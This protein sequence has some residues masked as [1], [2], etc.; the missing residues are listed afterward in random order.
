M[1]TIKLTMPIINPQVTLKTVVFKSL[2]APK[3]SG[4]TSQA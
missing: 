1:P 2:F 3:I 4:C